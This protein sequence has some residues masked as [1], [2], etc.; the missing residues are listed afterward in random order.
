MASVGKTAT[1]GVSLV[2]PSDEGSHE[3]LEEKY[4]Q[5][6]SCLQGIDHAT[7]VDHSVTD[8]IFVGEN[9]VRH[10]GYK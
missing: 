9:R 5:S 3:P 1:C 6:V 4:R 8:A 10:V 2:L 7:E